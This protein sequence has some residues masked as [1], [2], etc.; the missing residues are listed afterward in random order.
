MSDYKT[1]FDQIRE[2]LNGRDGQPIIFG[3]CMTLAKDWGLKPGLR[4]RLP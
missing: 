2:N 3:V 1:P 4:G